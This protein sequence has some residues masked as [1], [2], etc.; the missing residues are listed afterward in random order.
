MFELVEISIKENLVHKFELH[1]L[2]KII[3]FSLLYINASETPFK[4][5]KPF[6]PPL[7]FRVKEKH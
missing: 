4:R 2:S 7:C 5:F 6:Y 1:P 3:R